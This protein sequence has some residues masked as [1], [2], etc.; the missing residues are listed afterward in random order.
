MVKLVVKLQKKNVIKIKSAAVNKVL[1]AKVL[2]VVT[3]I[4]APQLHVLL[5]KMETE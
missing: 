4:V 2:L 1:T 3:N 5:N